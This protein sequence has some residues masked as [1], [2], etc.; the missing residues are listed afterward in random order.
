MA[1]T[2]R[3]LRTILREETRRVLREESSDEDLMMKFIESQ[4]EIASE[5]RNL[6]GDK[7]DPIDN[8]R[9]DI[10]AVASKINDELERVGFDIE[11]YMEALKSAMESR[12]VM[13]EFRID[14]Y[15]ERPLR[16]IE[17]IESEDSE[18]EEDEDEED[19]G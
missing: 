10:S 16:D 2:E 7:P 9:Q 6:Y 5:F 3:R 18:E 17:V 8:V 19:L 14:D 13:I 11:E 12:G 1:L 15:D 4:R